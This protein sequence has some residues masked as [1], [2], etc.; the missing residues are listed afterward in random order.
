MEGT[1]ITEKYDDAQ[2][3]L[4]TCFSF[5]ERFCAH[6]RIFVFLIGIHFALDSLLV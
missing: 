2:V 5:A 4:S 6:A 3:I 1:S